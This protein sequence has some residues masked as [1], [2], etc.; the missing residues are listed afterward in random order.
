MRMEYNHSGLKL[1]STHPKI[2]L[3]VWKCKDIE[4]LRAREGI[5]TTV[6][7]TY[8][9]SIHVEWTVSGTKASM[10]MDYTRHSFFS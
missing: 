5:N 4:G 8:Q 6:K 3:S 2:D 9:S 10:R 7:S 1:A